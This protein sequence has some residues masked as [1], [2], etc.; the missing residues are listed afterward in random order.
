MKK[1][2]LIFG[3]IVS[4]FLISFNKMTDKKTITLNVGYQSPTAATWGAIV[5]KNSG[6]LEKRLND[7]FPEYNFKINW[8]DSPTGMPLING[9]ISE[10]IDF[11]FVGDM[12]ALLSKNF[13]NKNFSPQI[14]AID[15]RGIGGRGQAIFS[16]GVSNS[17]TTAYG[18][19]AERLLNYYFSGK[20]TYQD[21]ASGLQTFDNKK[22]GIISVWEPY[23]SILENKG[24]K[25]VYDGTNTNIDYLSAVVINSESQNNKKL[26]K[27]FLNIFIETLSETHDWIS[28]NRQEAIDILSKNTGFQKNIVTETLNNITFNSSYIGNGE[29]KTFKSSYDFLK[30]RNLIDYEYDNDFFYVMSE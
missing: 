1:Y 11:A 23:V 7:S 5:M 13:Q 2:F 16:N 10:K 25:K 18:S 26:K 8:I 17:A 27:K 28:Q 6:E 24:I 29:L 22:V 12:P 20:T 4:I 30:K 21:L 9:L 19:S 14:I 3:L 15:G